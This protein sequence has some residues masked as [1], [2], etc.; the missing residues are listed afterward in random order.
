MP[1]DNYIYK[2]VGV[3]VH[4]GNGSH[5]H[6]YSYINTDRGDKEK[7][8]YTKEKE[9]LDVSK[10]SWREF[11][12]DEV[13]YFSFSSLVKEAYGDEVKDFQKSATSG[14]SAYMLVY[15]RKLKT[16]IRQIDITTED[17]TE[18]LMKYRD[19]PKFIPD[20]LENQ[21]KQDNINFIVDRQVF[22]DNFFIMIKRI[23]ETIN[24]THLY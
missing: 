18:S 22:D 1:D 24:S 7:D 5:G 20:W 17:K 21:V 23:L 10:D 12:D 15:E 13:K 19:V 14:K 6:Y 2:L 3:T 4:S 8:P 16:D 9:W 11:N